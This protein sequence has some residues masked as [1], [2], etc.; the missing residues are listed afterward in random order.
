MKL[1]EVVSRY[2]Y[3]NVLVEDTVKTYQKR[4]KAFDDRINYESIDSLALDD[5]FKWRDSLLSE[6]KS[7]ATINNY[8]RHCRAIWQFAMKQGWVNGDTNIFSQ[9]KL[10]EVHKKK[11]ISNKTIDAALVNVS[12]KF[13]WFWQAVILLQADLGIRNRQLVGLKVIDLCLGTQQISCS[14]E[15][16]KMRRENVLPLSES[17]VLVM[18]DFLSNSRIYLGRDLR[19]DEYLFEVGRYD[20]KFKKYDDGKMT[21]DQLQGMYH[22]LSNKILT[23]TGERISGHR[24]RHTLATR[25]GSHPDVNIRVVQEW[26]GWNCIQTA[27][28]YIQVSLEQKRALMNK[29]KYN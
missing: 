21:R 3:E 8:I 2:C 12:S 25:I 4:V 28:R 22:R 13:G 7:H 1:Q 15:S 29:T 18:S 14:A 16:N 9:R 26:F 6:G 19:P 10:P 27:Q 5:V 23:K 17:A 24:L 20:P 11:V